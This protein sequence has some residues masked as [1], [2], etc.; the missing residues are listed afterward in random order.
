MKS[1]YMSHCHCP[2]PFEPELNDDHENTMLLAPEQNK[3]KNK[4]NPWADNSDF[5]AAC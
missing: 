3:F 1:K 5:G 4:I 2:V